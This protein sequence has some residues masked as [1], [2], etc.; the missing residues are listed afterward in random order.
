V[1]KAANHRVQPAHLAGFS[2]IKK[3]REMI[4]QNQPLCKRGM[5][6]IDIIPKTTPFMHEN[7]DR[8]QKK[9]GIA[10]CFDDM[11]NLLIGSLPE[12]GAV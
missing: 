9:G 5:V 4:A 12:S 7:P 1:V 2:F 11:S 8:Y 10:M 6:L 3:G